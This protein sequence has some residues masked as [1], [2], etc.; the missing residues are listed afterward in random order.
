MSALRLTARRLPAA[1][2]G[3][4]CLLIVAVVDLALAHEHGLSGDEPFYARMATHPGGAHTFPYAYRVV[5]PW[6][7]HV[8]PVSQTTAVRGLAWLAR[9][10]VH[11]AAIPTR[12]RRD[13]VRGGGDQGDAGAA[14][15]AG[16]FSLRTAS[17][18]CSTGLRAGSGSGCRRR[19]W[20]PE[21][22]W[23]SG[24]SG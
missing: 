1:G 16:S 14:R 23:A 17:T 22:G 12:A 6:L 20:R 19:A 4:L 24:Q 3:A 9:L 18:S 11:R 7:V 2:V 10:P 21:G 13:A 15:A 8:L 5:L